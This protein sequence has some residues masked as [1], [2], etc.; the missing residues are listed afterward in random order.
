VFKEQSLYAVFNWHSSALM[1]TDEHEK[2]H[3][4]PASGGMMMINL[5]ECC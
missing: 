5:S 2:Q 3:V 4:L 1:S